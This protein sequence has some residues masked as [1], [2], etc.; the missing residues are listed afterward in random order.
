MSADTN[1]LE[2]FFRKEEVQNLR[3]LFISVIALSKNIGNTAPE[4]EIDKQFHDF[5]RNIHNC[6]VS[7]MKLPD[8]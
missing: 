2:L 4:N 7:K 8:C 6:L 5:L 3:Q 1:D